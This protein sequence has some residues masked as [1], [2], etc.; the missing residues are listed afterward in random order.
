MQ[1]STF[2]GV[3]SQSQCDLLLFRSKKKSYFGGDFADFCFLV[4]F[5]KNIFSLWASPPPLPLKKNFSSRVPIIVVYRKSEK[6][7]FPMQAAE[8]DFR[9]LIYTP[10]YIEKQKKNYPFLMHIYLNLVLMCRLLPY[11]DG[12]VLL[13]CKSWRMNFWKCFFFLRR[14]HTV[15]QL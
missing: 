3:Y 11:I 7:G 2:K 12:N 8:N 10:K 9:F 5:F 14:V 13:S 15:C 4:R 6:I 1:I